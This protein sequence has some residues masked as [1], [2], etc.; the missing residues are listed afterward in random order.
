MGCVGV[1]G[2]GSAHLSC[3]A[4]RRAGPGCWPVSMATTTSPGRS[5]RV[6]GIGAKVAAL[7]VGEVSATGE[8]R[9]AE[10]RGSLGPEEDF[11]KER[12]T[13]WKVGDEEPGQES[14]DE[15]LAN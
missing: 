14:R 5:P 6:P 11:L 10:G 7:V 4:E 13:G 12:V 8:G 2:G 3:Q 15:G 1:E 9:R